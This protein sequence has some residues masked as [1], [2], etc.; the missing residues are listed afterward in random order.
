M[1]LL[2]LNNIDHYNALPWKKQILDSMRERV[3]QAL[4]FRVDISPEPGGWWHQ[5]VCPEHSLPLIFN[6]SSPDKHFCS[7]GDVYEGAEYD[8]AFRVFAHRHYADLARDSAV[9]FQVTSEHRYLDATLKILLC[10][11][12]LYTGYK[13]NQQS[14]KWMTAGRVFQQALTEA[15]WT[16]PLAQSFVLVAEE[17]SNQQSEHI[18]NNLLKSLTDVL[19]RAHRELIKQDRLNSNYNAWLISGLGHLGFALNDNALVQLAI[20]EPGGF[21]AHLNAAILPDNME[22]EGSPYY[23]NFVA[24]A[25]TLLAETAL[26]HGIN[27]YEV[28]GSQGQSIQ[29]MWASLAS[30]MW[31]DGTIPFLDDGNYWQDS[32]FDRELCETYE[33]AFYHTEDERYAWLLNRAYQRQGTPRD[34][35]A[36]LSSANCNIQDTPQ[37]VMRSS[38]L[39]D[40]GLAMLH[41]DE[42]QNLAVLLR[43]GSCGG[44]HKHFDNLSIVLY[45]FS[46]DAGNPP[47]GLDSR[48]TWYQR[49]PAHNTVLVNGQ[50]QNKSTGKLISWTVDSNRTEAKASAND[51]YPGVE[52]SRKIAIQ[53][54]QIIDEVNLLA[55]SHTTF[56]WL[57]HLDVPLDFENIELISMSETS[58]YSEGPASL[59]SVVSRTASTD[60]FSAVF[61]A[62]DRT[63]RLTMSS[64]SPVEVFMAHSPK[65]GGIDMTRRYT[66][67]VRKSGEQ[68][69]FHATYEM[70]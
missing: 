39:P 40:A 12:D 26:S 45:P 11:A 63:Y 62:N 56:D 18:K 2:R 22:H 20:E 25:Y 54:K 50:V 10:Y 29:G 59:L 67:I 31:A 47:Y 35:W 14:Q 53:G 23:H 57:L 16:V 60:E 15:I 51:A 55:S 52:F 32:S 30:L 24:W 43:F 17:C 6:L 5:Y 36:A 41:T 38:Y 49:T 21:S 66:L 1:N 61:I 8:A 68:A 33:I 19:L 3:D 70:L 42:P 64:P 27:L 48:R 34:S 69:Q 46:A 4:Q 44:G 37:P 65:R 13:G 58:L 28:T 7:A 9:L